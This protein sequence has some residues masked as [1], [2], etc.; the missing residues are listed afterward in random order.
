M[1]P[2]SPGE[3]EVVPIGARR[4]RGESAEVGTTNRDGYLYVWEP[5]S[6]ARRVC[7]IGLRRAAGAGGFEPG[8]RDK[9]GVPTLPTHPP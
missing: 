8:F 6:S 7:E 5:W 4:T 3:F 1:V 2:R 9:R